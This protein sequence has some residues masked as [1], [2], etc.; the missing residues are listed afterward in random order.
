[1]GPD[2][3]TIG[4][5]FLTKEILESIIHPS[6]V[7]SDQ[8]AAQTVVTV[9]GLI[10]TGIVGSGG[11]GQL[12]VLQADGTKVPVQEEDV[13]EMVPARVSAMPE[14]LL[15]SL[16]LEDVTDLISFLKDTPAVSVTRNPEP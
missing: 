8:Y 10:Y 4:K 5:R 16:S 12:I 2:L 9:D 14:G 1:M 7:I 3:T 15:D 6:R 13:E 11:P